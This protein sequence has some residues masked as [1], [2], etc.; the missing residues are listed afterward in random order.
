MGWRLLLDSIHIKMLE[1]HLST[2][3]FRPIIPGYGMDM[4]K[5]HHEYSMDIDFSKLKY[6]LCYNM[7]TL[8]ILKYLGIKDSGYFL[9]FWVISIY[10]NG[11][12]LLPALRCL[13]FFDVGHSQDISIFHLF[14]Q[15]LTYCA[16]SL[17]IDLHSEKEIEGI[18][19]SP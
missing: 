17:C 1:M 18:T 10:S 11:L 12:V 15:G 13:C 19:Y 8:P 14:F 7:D 6:Q 16:L 9:A 2:L 3:T 4:T 5:T